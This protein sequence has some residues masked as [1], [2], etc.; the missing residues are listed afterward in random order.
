[1]NVSDENI[2]VQM[3]IHFK[4]LRCIERK[5]MWNW[6]VCAL[7]QVGVNGMLPLTLPLQYTCFR[8]VYN[9][10][11]VCVYFVFISISFLFFIFVFPARKI[12][13][14]ILF[15]STEPFKCSVYWYAVIW[16]AAK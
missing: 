14:L 5:S 4:H 3:E 7:P 8:A 11:W 13:H 6:I 10:I 15:I 12:F 9:I 1:M 16:N 2:Y